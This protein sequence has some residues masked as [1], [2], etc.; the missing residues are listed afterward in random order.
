VN[1]IKA[2]IT[3]KEP[4]M[5]AALASGAVGLA[6]SFGWSVTPTQMAIISAVS[7]VALAVLARTKVTPAAATFITKLDEALGVHAD[8]TIGPAPA[9]SVPGAAAVGGAA[10]GAAGAAAGGA[11]GGAL[12]SVLGAIT[13]A[14]KRG[15]PT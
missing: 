3:S 14:F 12:G 11:V 2:W 15:K 4:V 6:A 8:G 7:T 13:G 5:A 10:G 1:A 9:P